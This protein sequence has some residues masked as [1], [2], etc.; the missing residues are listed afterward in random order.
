MKP[1]KPGLGK[2]VVI[3]YQRDL[4]RIR[5]KKYFR[6]GRVVGTTSTPAF[7]MLGLDRL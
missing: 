5:C 7:L 6:V 1:I 3:W 2:P 4:S